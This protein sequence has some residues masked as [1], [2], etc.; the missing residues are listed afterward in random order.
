M[1]VKFSTYDLAHEYQIML[2]V[3]TDHGIPKPLWYSKGYSGLSVLALPLLCHD[4]SV[5]MKVPSASIMISVGIMV[6]KCSIS[7][8]QHLLS[9]LRKLLRLEHCHNRQVVHGDIKPSNFMYKGADCCD[10]SDI[11]LIDFGAAKDLREEVVSGPEQLEITPLYASPRVQRGNSKNL[12]T[13]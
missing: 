3:Q 1:C 2:L 11:Y 8:G 5:A 9:T 7:P 4:F 6:S 12:N 13:H 10:A